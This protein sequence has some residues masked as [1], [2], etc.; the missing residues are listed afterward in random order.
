L[1]NDDFAFTESV[2]CPLLKLSRNLKT[3]S[4]DL[5]DKCKLISASKPFSDISN[6]S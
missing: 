4:I 3:N 1:G 2:M 6:K 5:K